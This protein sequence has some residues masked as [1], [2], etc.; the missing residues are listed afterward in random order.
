MLFEYNSDK[1]DSRYNMAGQ[2]WLKQYHMEVP[3]EDVMTTSGTQNAL[4]I[5]LLSF[6]KAGDKIAIDLFSYPNFISLAN[7][8]N[9]QLIAIQILIVVI[10]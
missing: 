9:I 5:S 1:S 3:L 10:H 2:K 6:F 7:L 8:L 4:V